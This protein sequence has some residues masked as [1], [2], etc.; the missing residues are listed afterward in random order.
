MI[1]NPSRQF[2]RSLTAATLVSVFAIPPALV[3][4]ATEHLVTPSDLTKA[5]VDASQKR[6]QNL[7]TLK[8]LFSSK[9][10]QKALQSANMN[11]RKVENSIASL[12]DDEL[13]QLASKANRAQNEFAAGT[14][15]DRDLI[16][17]L[18]AIAALILI[19]VAVR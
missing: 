9:R 1:Q 8:R 18:I 13:A 19:I 16:L 11:P 17:I 6:Q 4:Q 3:A 12:S 14:M 5:A 7:E 15:S 2:L 10:A